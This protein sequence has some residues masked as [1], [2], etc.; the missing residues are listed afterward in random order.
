VLGA[1]GDLADFV[2][3]TAPPVDLDWRLAGPAEEAVVAAGGAARLDIASIRPAQASWPPVAERPAA[4]SESWGA[5]VS[6]GLHGA[7]LLALLVWSTPLAETPP[8]EIVTVEIVN[9]PPST[10]PENVPPPSEIA[11]AAPVDAAAPVAAPAAAPDIAPAPIA[12]APRTG[13]PPQT[14]EPPSAPRIVEPSPSAVVQAPVP[15][16]S[17]PESAAEAPAPPPAA[18]PS[19]VSSS[20]VAPALK[21]PTTAA[22]KTP[23]APPRATTRAP[24]DSALKV[25]K[26]TRPSSLTQ[27]PAA[28][29]DIA[30]YQGEVVRRIIATKRYPEAARERGTHGIAVVT[31]SIGA[32]GQVT[33]AAITRSAGD[34]ILDTDALATVRRASPFPPPPVGA[35]RRFAASLNYGVR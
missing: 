3:A 16:P 6:F 17:K 23:P 20:V 22:L 31:F 35:A 19:S 15:V 25:A 4:R 30:A 28:A 11:P 33:S 12:Q 32:S 26:P 21:P 13:E 5:A 10:A 2:C 27:S 7:A 9:A 24:A 18:R 29:V 34:P 8:P 1:T 14:A